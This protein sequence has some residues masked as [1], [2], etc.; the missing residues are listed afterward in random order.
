M[1]RRAFSKVMPEVGQVVPSDPRS[2]DLK[3]VASVVAGVLV[4]A[5]V[6][7]ARLVVEV[8]DLTC[9]AGTVVRNASVVDYSAYCF[10]DPRSEHATSVPLRRYVGL[11]L[12]NVDVRVLDAEPGNVH[13]P[14]FGVRL[15][16]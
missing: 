15:G 11:F 3:L 4:L 14:A 5:L 8:R 16:R 1:T 12:T 6:L 13:G 7:G 2:L 10:P 9:P